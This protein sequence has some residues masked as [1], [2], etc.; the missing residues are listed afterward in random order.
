MTS[1]GK[2]HL[3]LGDANSAKEFFDRALAIQTEY[4]GPTH[5][6]VVS[7][8]TSLGNAWHVLGDTQCAKA[9]FEQALA[10]QKQYYG[11]MHVEVARILKNVGKALLS[12]DDAQS[13]KP[14][15]EEASAIQNEDS[16]SIRGLGVSLLN[17]GNE[18]RDL[19]DTR[20]QQI[21]INDNQWVDPC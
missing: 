20:E 10:I 18:R 3:A 14:Y 9:Y 2:A 4:Y 1:L 5:V 19:R 17:L 8:L 21:T 16:G 13:A 12:R 15:L 6:A 11:S 7:T